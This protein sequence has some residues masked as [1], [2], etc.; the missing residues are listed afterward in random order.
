MSVNKCVR[1]NIVRDNYV[2]KYCCTYESDGRAV[3]SLLLP[4]INFFAPSYQ[5]HLRSKLSDFCQLCLDSYDAENCQV[6][7]NFIQRN[8]VKIT[9]KNVAC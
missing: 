6:Y 3:H 2:G 8:M 7:R 1:D 9:T 5:K 4:S